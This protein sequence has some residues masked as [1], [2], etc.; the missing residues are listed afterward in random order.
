VILGV[1]ARW[2]AVAL[3]LFLIPTTLI[4]HTTAGE[5]TQFFKNLSLLGG[6]LLL[7]ATGS[8]PLSLDGSGERES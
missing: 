5:W 3:I 6:L 8:G 4:F 1:R 7:T 2:G